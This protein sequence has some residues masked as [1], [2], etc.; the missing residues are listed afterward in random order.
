MKRTRLPILL[1][2]AAMLAL[3]ACSTKKNDGTN[4]AGS[5]TEGAGGSMGG[6]Y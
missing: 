6:G 2:V 5:T 1:F 3:T 4:G